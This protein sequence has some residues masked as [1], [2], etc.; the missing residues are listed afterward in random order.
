MQ[1]IPDII[2][3]T[4]AKNNFGELIRRVF[5][6]GESV[7][8]AKDGLPVVVISPI[9]DRNLERMHT[10]KPVSVSLPPSKTP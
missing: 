3:A 2:S 6:T 8:V 4:K 5:N 1:S 7:I 9:R 10:E